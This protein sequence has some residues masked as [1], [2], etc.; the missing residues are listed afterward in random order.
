MCELFGISASRP[1]PVR[2]TPLG[3]FPQRG[4]VTADNPDGWG[5]AWLASDA[6]GSNMQMAKEPTPGFE[7]QLFA[8]LIQTQ[9]ADLVISHVRKARF[10]PVN[11]L[12]NTH[13]F[14]RQCCGRTWVFAHNGLVPQIVGLEQA[15]PERFCQPKGETDSEFA[16]CHLLGSLSSHPEHDWLDE[17]SR[18]SEAIALTG[19]FNFLLSDGIHLIAYGH[20]RLHYL[21]STDNLEQVALVA[22]EPLSECPGW[23]AFAP[24]ELRIYR[25][26]IRVSHIQSHSPTG[27]TDQRTV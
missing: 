22:T 11:N 16:F 25:A 6:H 10:P 7:S 15:N 18:L 3:Q 2:N 8:Q 14:L 27:T 4:G 9:N 13:P 5:M 24:G 12:D 23:T 17:L 19:K 1:I 26:G 21:E 20:D